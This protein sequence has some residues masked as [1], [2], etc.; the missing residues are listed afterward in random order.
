MAALILFLTVL[1]FG[2]ISAC[3]Q[4]YSASEVA[5]STAIDANGNPVVSKSSTSMAPPDRFIS[6]SRPISVIVDGWWSRGYAQASCEAE[7]SD[8]VDTDLVLQKLRCAKLDPAAAALDFEDK[9]M[10]YMRANVRCG[11]MIVARYKGP[12]ESSVGLYRLMAA[13]HWS[14]AL[15]FKPAALLQ[16]WSLSNGNGAYSQGESETLE[17]MAGDIC[18]AVLRAD[19]EAPTVKDKAESAMASVSRN[20][21]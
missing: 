20:V 13:P 2:N 17:R 8:A 21:R 7:I 11:T 15:N 1:I 16:T 9:L 14:L 10:N 18:A 4:S 12:S 19:P 5:R 3:A 6:E